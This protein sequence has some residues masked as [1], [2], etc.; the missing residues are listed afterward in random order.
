YC[1]MIDDTGSFVTFEGTSPA[2]SGHVSAGVVGRINGG[3]TT[4]VFTGT[5]N[6]HP[7]YATH[8]NLGT[9]DLECTDAYTCNGAYPSFLSYFTGS[10][11]WDY[12]NWGWAYHTAQN[13]T[14]VNASTGNTGDITG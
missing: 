4:T 7:A 3:Y 6:P 10:P 8:G 9:F 13:G 14:W 12:A 2:G 5:V 1:A 11:S